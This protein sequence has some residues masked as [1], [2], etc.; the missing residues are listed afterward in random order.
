MVA[1]LVSLFTAM[2]KGRY[3]GKV[4]FTVAR[5]LQ[6]PGRSKDRVRNYVVN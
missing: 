3:A 4:R 2:A 1:V 5:L 6:G